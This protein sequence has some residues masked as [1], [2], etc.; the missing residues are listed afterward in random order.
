MNWYCIRRGLQY[1][2]KEFET[3]YRTWRN[4]REIARA[5]ASEPKVVVSLHRPSAPQVWL[6]AGGLIIA[7]AAYGVVTVVWRMD[8][9]RVR[10]FPL[11]QR[12]VAPSEPQV[13][14]PLVPAGEDVSSNRA[15]TAPI[16]DS[17]KPVARRRLSEN[18]LEIPDTMSHFLVMNKQSRRM[19]LLGNRGGKWAV[20]RTYRVAI[21]EREGRKERSGDRRTPEGQYFITGQKD[22]SELNSIYGPLAY[23]LNYPNIEDRKAGRTGEGIWI[24]GTASDTIPYRT[25]GCLEMEN[26]RLL[27]LSALLGAGIGTPVLIVN[28]AE[29]GDPAGAPDYR[30]AVAARKRVM[31]MYRGTRDSFVDLLEEWASAWESRDIENYARFYEEE[32][33]HAQGMG[34]PD[35]RARKKGTFE[36][37]RTID[38]SLDNIILSDFSESTAVV[39]FMQQYSSD[40]IRVAN[41]K[42]LAFVR[43]RGEW[44]IYRESTL[45][46]E[47]TTL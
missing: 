7:V 11:R 33:F 17:D 42:K 41:R 20:F 8:L 14:G 3:R 29:L 27:E 18:V 26:E 43:N 36:A 35:W 31:L 40:R 4:A 44:K 32:R 5:Y 1:L 2:A 25:R 15:A 39:K 22:R 34:W 37:Y 13:S 38:I 9:R 30:A 10:A 6:V 47:E 21:G 16:R 19:F 12:A 45:P 28:T 46:R 23:V 24:H